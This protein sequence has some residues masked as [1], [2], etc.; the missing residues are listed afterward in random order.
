HSIQKSVRSLNQ[1]ALRIA[2]AAAVPCKI[3][4]IRVAAISRIITEYH[5]NGIR[6]A[7]ESHTIQQSVRS[8]YHVPVIRIGAARGR[9]AISGTKTGA[10]TINLNDGSFT[11]LAS[12]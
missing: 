7:V 12:R 6:A 1:A 9:P 3:V 11:A 2:P 8:L 4:Q 5:S 10:V